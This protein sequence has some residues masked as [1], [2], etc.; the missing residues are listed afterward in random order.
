MDEKNA[1]GLSAFEQAV[2]TV[3]NNRR[4]DILEGDM[5]TIK[6]IVYET[7]TSTK[8]I[9]KS[10]KKIEKNSEHVRNT[11]VGGFIMG[12]ISIVFIAIKQLFG[13]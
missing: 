6:P 10:V 5:K 1:S 3:N 13:I 11:V 7:A 9:E 2:M 12:V 8:Q 4:L